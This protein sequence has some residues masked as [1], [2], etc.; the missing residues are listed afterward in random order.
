[1]MLKKS[2]VFIFILLSNQAF[3]QNTTTVNVEVPGKKTPF[4]TKG[5]IQFSLFHTNDMHGHA[6]PYSEPGN[7]VIGGLASIQT[8]I[9]PEAR[10]SAIFSDEIMLLLDGGDFSLGTLR[11][12][13]MRSRP[14]IDAMNQ[15]GYT[16]AAMGQAELSRG[17]SHLK[18][19][20]KQSRFTLLASNAFLK[21]KSGRQRLSETYIIKEIDGVRIGI[22]GLIHPS[23]KNAVKFVM[24][25]LIIDDPI[26]T[27]RKIENKIHDKVDLLIAISH[28]G[29]RPKQRFIQNRDDVVLA[30]ATKY[31]DVI[32]GGASHSVLSGPL[33]IHKKLIVQAG[34]NTQY[35]GRL[36]LALDPKKQF[37]IER[38]LYS[39]F[40]INLKIPNPNTKSDTKY[41]NAWQYIRPDTTINK[42]LQ[43]YN[44]H[45]RSLS[46][47][48]I[49]L[50]RT[51][52][53]QMLDPPDYSLGNYMADTLRTYSK[54]DIALIPSQNIGKLIPTGPLYYTHLLSASPKQNVLVKGRIK[55]SALYTLMKHMMTLRPE[56]PGFLL[57]SGF[58]ISKNSENR[59]E[60]LFEGKPLNKN[61]VFLV[62]TT[63]DL[64]QPSWGY[65]V[66]A[67]L[68]ERKV[69][70][71]TLSDILFQNFMKTRVI[72]TADS[73]PRVPATF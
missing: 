67:L 56:H 20:G 46:H 12:D 69:I 40:P 53:M 13:V 26:R 4:K 19:I 29:I 24:P 58:E 61:Q 33:L 64:A 54:A 65:P 57:I 41:V 9:L 11:N 27:A 10:R 15:M 2:C 42:Q 51:P 16:A 47:R 23:I 52:L 73:T 63:S 36:T 37:E 39:Q 45:L 72:E 62:T 1:M 18:T 22:I 32:V 34:A 49:G 30:K 31:I 68:T 48:Q 17:L 14:M 38:Y 25:N 28:M 5:L 43:T 66:Q 35:L 55:G 50:S 21:T 44:Q 6:W 7:E 71:Q 60:L 3:S 70:N 8:L 59:F